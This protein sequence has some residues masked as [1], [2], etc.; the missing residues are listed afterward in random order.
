MLQVKAN[1][2]KWFSVERSSL[3]QMEHLK[4]IKT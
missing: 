4:T 2:V 3:N 1:F